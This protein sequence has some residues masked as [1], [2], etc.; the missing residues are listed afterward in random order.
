MKNGAWIGL[1]CTNLWA[2]IGY[3]WL[4]K[5][6]LTYNQ[7]DVTAQYDCHKIGAI[8]VSNP[9]GFNGAAFAAWLHYEDSNTADSFVCS[10]EPLR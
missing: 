6:L 9:A 10:R 3:E 2:V 7:F 8:I 1:G 5:S 4:D